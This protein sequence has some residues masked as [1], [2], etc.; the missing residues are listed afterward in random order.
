MKELHLDNTYLSGTLPDWLSDMPMLG[1]ERGLSLHNT[2]LSGTLPFDICE[3]PVPLIRFGGQGRGSLD[4][5]SMRLH[6]AI[7]DFTACTDL[8]SLRLSNNTFTDLP[9]GLPPSVTHLYLDANPLNATAADLSR[10]TATLPSLHAL[11]VGLVNVPIILESFDVIFNEQ[12]GVTASHTFCFGTRVTPPT[13]CVVGRAC[14]WVLHLHDA[15]DQPA[16][17]GSLVMGLALGVNCSCDRTECPFVGRV[18]GVPI[19]AKD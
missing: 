4:L 8:Q 10:L 16:L 14:S 18:F 12:C 11:D 2:G 7:P 17:T 13:G 15:D 19:Y 5:H 6:G 3:H 9:P 1:M